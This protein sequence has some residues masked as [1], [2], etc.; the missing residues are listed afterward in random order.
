[1]ST[2]KYSVAYKTIVPGDP[3]SEKAY[4]AS[5][6]STDKN[7]LDALCEHIS[8]HNSKY[9][10]GD[11]RAV[12]TETVDCMKE[13][14]LNG[15]IVNLGSEF[16]SFRLTVRSAPMSQSAMDE[17]NGYY[18]TNYI[19]NVNVVWKKGSAFNSL[20]PEDFSFTEVPTIRDQDEDMAVR[21]A[22]RVNRK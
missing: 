14:L 8:E 17:N 20:R 9:N 4:Y 11:I 5:V 21:R 19:R 12:L 22:N 7:L 10:R 15:D 2:L 18:D 16:G 3:S 6:Q 13:M 1:M